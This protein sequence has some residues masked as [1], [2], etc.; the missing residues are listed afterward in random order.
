MIIY[1]EIAKTFEMQ[2]LLSPPVGHM[3]EGHLSKPE[4]L[5][6]AAGRDGHIPV[7][8][9]RLPHHG[10]PGLLVRVSPALTG[11]DSPGPPP[12]PGSASLENEK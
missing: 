3:R 6:A 9:G 12:R 1:V 5:R 10:L 2:T 8:S 11:R 4:E 7:Q